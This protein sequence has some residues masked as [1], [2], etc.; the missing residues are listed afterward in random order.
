MAWAKEKG[1]EGDYAAVCKTSEANAMILDELKK[2]GK[3]AK[4]KGFEIVKAVHLDS[5]QFSV[6]EKALINMLKHLE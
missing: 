5:V 4:M 3:E 6:E 1:I 2:T